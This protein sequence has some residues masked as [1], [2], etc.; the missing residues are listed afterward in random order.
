[1]TNLNQNNKQCKRAVWPAS[2]TTP[3]ENLAQALVKTGGCVTV[4]NEHNPSA[5]VTHALDKAAGAKIPAFHPA[6][7]L[8]PQASTHKVSAWRANYAREWRE[9][10]NHL[11]AE[12]ATDAKRWMLRNP[13][14]R[15]NDEVTQ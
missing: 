7:N 3:T 1:M 14:S 5:V 10:Q 6:A 13:K 12:M 2:Q 8:L 15:P 4:A 11:L 9:F